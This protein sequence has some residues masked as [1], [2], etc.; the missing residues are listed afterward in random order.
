MKTGTKKSVK[1]KPDIDI[2]L[3]PPQIISAHDFKIGDKVRIHSAKFL[4]AEVTGQH[5]KNP[6]LVLCGW[7][8]KHGDVCE[9]YFNCQQLTLIEVAK[10]PAVEAEEAN[11]GK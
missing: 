8:N 5:P 2:I 9:M 4:D 7:L 6:K 10:K 11:E 3:E 1:P